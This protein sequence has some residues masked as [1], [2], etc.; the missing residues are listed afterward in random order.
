VNDT[1]HDPPLPSHGA[2][3]SAE[4][5]D[6]VRGTMTPAALQRRLRSAVFG[7][8]VFYYATIGSTNDRALELAADGEPEGGLVLAEEQTSGRGRRD[9]SWHSGARLGIYASVIL[10]PRVP[11]P[12]APLF[13]FTAAVAVASAIREACG[14]EARIK[15]PNDVLVGPRKIA[16]ILGETRGSEPVIREM[17]VG[18]GVNV[19]QTATDFPAVVRDSATSVLIETGSAT[20][21]ATVLAAMLEGFERRYGMVLRGRSSDVLSEWEA[22]S[23]A[24][25][26]RAVVAE[27]PDGRIEGSVAGVDEEGALLL[28]VAGGRV[29]KLPF[30][31]IVQWF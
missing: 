28:L 26:G 6:P 14:L 7:H 30:G 27:G 19:N 17:V 31:E 25:R 10:R 2:T 5:D 3:R 12:R 24:P 4:P 21:R 1:T 22:L 11:A 20:D 9:R 15:W 18:M 13:T 8:R 29:V 23:A 16:G